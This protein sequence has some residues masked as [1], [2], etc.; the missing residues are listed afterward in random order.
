[1]THRKRRS[2]R[3][4]LE[5]LEGRIVLSQATVLTEPPPAVVA[6]DGFGIIAAATD[7]S[8]AIVNGYS[9]TATLSLASGPSGA[10]FTPVTVTMTGGEAIFDDL[11]LSQLSDGTDYV[12]RITLTNPSSGSM[13]TTTDPV[14]V[15]G[16]TAGVS[17]YYP[18]PTG[19]D[20]RVAVLSADFDG[21]PTSVITLSD[22]ALPYQINSGELS[23]F[24]GA[25]GSKTIDIVGQ[26]EGS[27]I[28]AAGGTSRVFEV[29]GDSSLSVAFQQLGISGGKAT[30]DGSDGI[31]DA[32]G[33]GV[34]ID[35]G[36]VT[37]SGVEL[38]NNVAQG[39]AGAAGG[40][41]GGGGLG[42]GIYLASGDLV[43]DN[44][45]I[46][47]NIARGGAGGAGAPAGP[48]A[49]AAREAAARSTR[50]AAPSRSPRAT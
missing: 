43:L 7:A 15:V 13:S 1:M 24:N 34:L 6:N 20:M 38:T 23:L 5:I 14:A 28:V 12:F 39:A 9:G 47:S 36:N 21:S 30:D 22:S 2:T 25:S 18:L 16:P 29:I 49:P 37:M 17:N 46:E 8:G 44:D 19:A 42:G 33:G 50:P 45:L 4:L 27:S 3:P 32:A 35:G 11:S 31:P 26:G 41:A 10:S 48:V 40:G